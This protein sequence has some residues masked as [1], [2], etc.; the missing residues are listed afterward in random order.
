MTTKQNTTL[1]GR[2]IKP[3]PTVLRFRDTLPKTAA[4]Y[5]VSVPTVRKWFAMRGIPTRGPGNFSRTPRDKQTKP[6]TVKTDKVET[7]GR[8]AF[9]IPKGF[10]MH[11]TIRATAE[12]YGVSPPTATKWLWQVQQHGKTKTRTK[13]RTKIE[14]PFRANPPSLPVPSI[15]RADDEPGNVASVFG[16]SIAQAKQWL[17][18]LQ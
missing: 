18:T 13:T 14:T 11:G 12:V 9:P 7:R 17:A 16:V 5:G 6:A 3:V 2:P 4:F 8:K 1:N 10:S 15:L